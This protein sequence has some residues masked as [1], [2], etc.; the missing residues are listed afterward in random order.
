MTGAPSRPFLAALVGDEKVEA[1]F[2]NE[3]ELAA[4]LAVEVALADAEAKAGLTVFDLSAVGQVDWMALAL[5]APCREALR[6]RGGD[7]A[8]VGVSERLAAALSRL[9][10]TGRLPVYDSVDSARLARHFGFG[11]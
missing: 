10:L 6:T 9:G 1:L 7:L 2:S 3:V 8:L 4:L 5:L 11:W